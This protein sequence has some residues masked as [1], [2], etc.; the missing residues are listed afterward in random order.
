MKH[1]RS[2]RY[3]LM[4]TFAFI[5]AFWTFDYVQRPGTQWI[6]AA[7]LGVLTG[8]TVRWTA[9]AAYAMTTEAREKTNERETF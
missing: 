4:A 3:L 9:R 6:G 5:T 1:K 8:L 7:V 2:D